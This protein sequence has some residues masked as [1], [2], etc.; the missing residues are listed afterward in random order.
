IWFTAS[1]DWGAR[2]VYA[3]TPAGKLRTVAKVP[4]T[5][6][7]RDIA[8]DGRVLISR[9]N[10]RLEMTAL[11]PGETTERDISLQDWSRLVGLSPDGGMILFEESGTAAAGQYIAYLY[12]TSDHRAIRLGE[13][14]TQAFSPDLKSALVVRSDDRTRLRLLGIDGG[15]PRDF[16]PVG[17]QY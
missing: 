3:V 10:R 9:E 5:I 14:M 6:A 12:R 7:L 13:G 4:A 11:L 15:P 8:P 2:S 16:E 17:L 1:R